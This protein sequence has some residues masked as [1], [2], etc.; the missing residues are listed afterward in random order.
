MAMEEAIS[1]AAGFV[2][3]TQDEDSLLDLMFVGE[4]N[5]VET[6]TQGRSLAY[7]AQMLEALA[8]LQACPEDDFGV[9]EKVVLQHAD[10]FAS[11]V[12]ILLHCDEIRRQLVQQLTMA[13]KSVCVFLVVDEQHAMDEKEIT[14]IRQMTDQCFVLRTKHMQ[15]DL[16]DLKFNDAG[17]RNAA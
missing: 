14:L 15:Q 17:Q 8:T 3:Q 12:L 6:V 2:A 13:D 16:N 7:E 1:L 5:H 11:C 10:A 9:L 4:R